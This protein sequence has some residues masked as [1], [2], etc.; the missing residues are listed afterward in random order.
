[1]IHLSGYVPVIDMLDRACAALV[2]L[3]AD[4]ASSDHCVPGSAQA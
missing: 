1:V 3:A 4:P 2:A